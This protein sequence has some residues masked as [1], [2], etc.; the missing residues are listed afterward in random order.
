MSESQPLSTELV[1]PIQFS[2]RQLAE[3]RIVSHDMADSRPA[4][5]FRDLRTQ[6][7]ARQEG[8]PAVSLVSAVQRHSG[9][10]FVALNLAAAIAFDES[11]RAVLVDC[12]LR[13]PVLHERLAVKA[14]R[15]GLVDY[16]EGQVERLEDILYPT[17]VARL[18]LIPAG[19]RR[20]A[21]GELLDSDRMRML[22]DSLRGSDGRC[23]VV[24]DGPAVSS[25]PD[26]RILSQLADF[27]VL[28][29]GYGRETTAALKEA[30]AVF[31]PRRLCGVVF[32]RVP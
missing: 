17:G 20:E 7:L 19:Q 3:R 15:G 30:A 4:D 16:L 6:L 11:R 23:S 13:A 32:N 10:S 27:S 31:D 21:S 12:N 25:S 9:G 14:E 22:L 26:A 8:R 5:A 24:L 2:G 1:A 28:V 18:M 29:A